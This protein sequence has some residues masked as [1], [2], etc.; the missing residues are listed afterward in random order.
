MPKVMSNVVQKFLNDLLLEIF[1]KKGVI[2][3]EK[4]D[5]ICEITSLN[6]PN[7]QSR[8]KARARYIYK[9]RELHKAELQYDRAKKSYI[10]K[11]IDSFVLNLTLSI[12]VTPQMLAAFSAGNVFVQKFLPHLKESSSELQIKL[13]RI[14]GKDLF[15]EGRSLASSVTMSL[16][17]ARIDGT[18]FSLVQQ[19][20]REKKTISFSYSTPCSSVT[21]PAKQNNDYSP[22]GLYFTDKS[23]YL[24]G[25]PYLSKTGRPFKLCRMKDVTLGEDTKFAPPPPG[26]EPDKILR[27]IWTARPGTPEHDVE[28][29]FLPPLSASIEE[30]EWPEEVEI[31][32]GDTVGEIIL[33]TKVPDLHG[34]AFFVLAGA[35]FAFAL[36]PRK[37]RNLVKELS[38]KQLETQKEIDY[39]K[40]TEY[41]LAQ[42][43]PENYISEED[44]LDMPDLPDLEEMWAAI[45]SREAGDPVPA[46]E[47]ERE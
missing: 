28:L 5:E 13:E 25:G 16:P 42:E 1:D 32:K 41:A 37:L 30:T 23:W 20:I 44:D 35:P 45:D 46:S 24:W 29:S 2:T 22:W 7:I 11:N 33:R 15:S 12:Q 6:T 47:Y 31:T 4:L 18:V 10:L 21:K 43:L 27:S 14:F 26:Q 9:L 36:Q 8:Q 40:I 39:D 17:T 19:A 38:A 3:T 34:V